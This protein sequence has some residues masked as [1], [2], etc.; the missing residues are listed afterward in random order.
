MKSHTVKLIIPLQSYSDLI[1]NSSSTVFLGKKDSTQTWS[2]IENL[3]YEYTENHLFT[4]TY[5]EFND[6]T[7]E[8]QEKY[9]LESGTGGFVS[10]INY[11]EVPSDG[12]E[13]CYFRGLKD[14]E[15]YFIVDLDWNLYATINWLCETFNAKCV[16]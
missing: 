7:R 11:S 4:G 10:V 9:N 12:W 1:T 16:E 3:I 6:L 5:E 13:R 15:N 14:P 2:Q 8:E